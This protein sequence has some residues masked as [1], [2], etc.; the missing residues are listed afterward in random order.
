MR[1]I[2]R[3]VFLFIFMALAVGNG[4][5]QLGTE[6]SNKPIFADSLFDRANK[7]FFKAQ[8]DSSYKNYTKAAF[9]YK[10]T[11]NQHRYVEA[12]YHAAYCL[13]ILSQYDKALVLLKNILQ[14]ALNRNPKS[15]NTANCYYYLAD[16]YN[17][18]DKNDK[19]LINLKKSLKIKK[20]VLKQDDP[21]IAVIYNLMGLAYK[22]LEDYRNAIAYY[23][24][25][26][27]IYKN[28]TNVEMKKAD[29]YANLGVGYQE[30]GNYK[31]A[32]KYQL[33]ALDINRRLFG[34]DYGDLA[35]N[36]NNLAI[37]YSHQGD[38]AKALQYYKKTLDLDRR[39]LGEKHPYVA[40]DYFNIATVYMGIYK[41]KEA[42]RFLDKARSIYKEKYSYNSREM[43]DVLNNFGVCYY[44]LKNYQKALTYYQK[45]LSIL[46]K[47]IPDHNKPV[48]ADTYF[49]MADIYL[50]LGNIKKAFSYYHQAL[51]GFKKVFG[52]YNPDVAKSLIGLG[53][54]YLDEKKYK[55]ALRYLDRAV[56]ALLPAGKIKRNV[57]QASLSDKH[58]SRAI[59]LKADAWYGLYR[60]DSRKISRLK[61]VQS[62]LVQVL[63]IKQ[64]MQN[65][66]ERRQSKLALSKELS[67]I[68]NRLLNVTYQLYQKT[69]A[70]T[71]KNEM[72]KL[73]EQNRSRL[74][75]RSLLQVRAKKTA[76][77]PDSL[78]NRLNELR[79]DQNIVKQKILQESVDKTKSDT[80][81]IRNY[82]NRLF[83][84]NERL[85]N[86]V[87]N[88]RLQYPRYNVMVDGSAV[89][90][91]PAVQKKMDE[92][93][94]LVEFGITDSVLF[95]LVVS[96]ESFDVIATPIDSLFHPHIRSFLKSLRRY[97]KLKWERNNRF[98][99]RKVIK[100][101]IHSIKSG[102]HLVIIP[103]GILSRFPFEAVKMPDESYLIEK[104]D[105]SYHNSATLWLMKNKHKN[106][107]PEGFAGFAPVFN[108]QN[109]REN[110]LA[111][112]V[113]L[114]RSGDSTVWR[115]VTRDGRVFNP[116]PFSKQEVTD[117]AKICLQ[118]R[119]KPELFIENQA[120]EEA[121][122]K[123]SKNKKFIHLAT[124][125]II[126]EE[127]PGLS[128]LVF[129]QLAKKD[130]LSDGVLYSGEIYNLDLN[131][132]LLVLS[133]CES[134][135]GKQVAGEGALSLTRGFLYAGVRN[136]VVSLWKI[137][138]KQTAGL[139]IDFYRNIF[140][141]YTFAKALRLAKLSRLKIAN[142]SF[143]RNWA[144]F[145]LIG[146]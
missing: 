37:I 119:L 143:P 57:T 13:T 78:L 108:S 80:V 117:I 79:Q 33:M 65:H 20:A 81:K 52:K 83:S 96:K 131:A 146:K 15:L 70:P 30:S 50:A 109:S 111:A 135:L 136:V 77:V 23:R 36:Y 51:K 25:A 4:F 54:L 8:Y 71:Y 72:F 85:D 10:K 21:D 139:M 58:L 17:S 105:I 28:N 75:Y 62:A 116:L 74:L 9:L 94:S 11:N 56:N 124:H 24:K 69:K 97:D 42:L 134:G 3:F 112:W 127:Y 100:P 95:T 26:L 89:T 44:K 64:R 22:H 98:V 121:F 76:G 7:F 32:L 104:Y 123:N 66:V 118:N 34:D 40:D 138:D 110:A 113:D 16:L 60:S 46:E 93:T 1:C 115:S 29:V 55:Q 53:R 101:F 5:A 132:D 19:A 128:G 59:K 129:S 48:Y 68:S 120:S 41:H 133:A 38:F 126:D 88:I 18:M 63:K 91:I 87:K 102:R 31:K 73:S 14:V 114:F 141:G 12:T 107:S 67:A 27:A 82:Q 92:R 140:N 144:G 137:S 43:A 35:V 106:H 47:I 130:S 6:P 45:S 125:G 39:T 145:V 90:T 61:S 49:N 142:T 84:I 122:K 86:L 2:K 99:Y 103:D